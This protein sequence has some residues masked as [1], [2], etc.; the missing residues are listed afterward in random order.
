MFKFLNRSANLFPVQDYLIPPDEKKTIKV[1]AIF[2]TSLTGIAM[3]KFFDGDQALTVKLT[4]EKN[5]SA[6]AMHNKSPKLIQFKRNSSIGIV[7]TRSLGYY[8]VSHETLHHNLLCDYSF[9]RL[10]ELCTF[11]NKMVDK[12][13]ENIANIMEKQKCRK[14][15]DPYPWLALDD[16]RRNMTDK[17]ILDKYINLSKSDLSAKEKK[18]LMKMIYEH[19]PAFSL[20]DEIGQCPNITIDIDVI[21]KSPFF[22]RPFP[23]NEKDKPIMDWQMERLVHF[24]ILSKNST[25]HTSPVMLITRKLTNDKRPIVD[26]RL[27]N[28]RIL[29]RNTA[30]PLLSDIFQILGNSKCELLSYIDLKDAFHSLKLSNSAKELCGILPYFGSSHYRYEVLPMGLSISPCKWMEY[31]RILIESL[32]HKSSYIAIM[33]DL[34]IHSLKNAHFSR[35]ES[36]FKAVIKHGLKISP[37]KC[38]LVMTSLMYLGNTFTITG[39]RMKITLPKSRTEAISK[40]PPPRTTKQCKSF[41]GVVNYVGIFCPNLQHYLKPLYELTKK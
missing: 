8:K 17:E 11:F 41:C 21:D 32:D 22:V 10:D 13:N 38:Q 26:F 19:R 39:S 35:L 33:D 12:V 28:T 40:L 25:S 7:D 31:V 24:G 14:Q 36:L 9:V 23:I 15:P 2:P 18:K 3:G 5:H 4:L 29:R 30:T 1:Q 34:L 16:P 20:R 27:L 37:K 6:F